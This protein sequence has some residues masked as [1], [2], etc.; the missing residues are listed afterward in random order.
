MQQ[1]VENIILKINFAIILWIEQL[2]TMFNVNIKYALSFGIYEIHWEPRDLD[3]LWPF[4]P[5]VWSL[6]FSALGRGMTP[7]NPQ[8]LH[9]STGVH[10]FFKELTGVIDLELY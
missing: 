6:D 9:T 3:K 1:T 10:C 4:Y 2:Q 7:C 8:G 5:T